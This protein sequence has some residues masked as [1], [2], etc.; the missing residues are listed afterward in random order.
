MDPDRQC[1][2]KS[3][4]SGNRCK[5]YAV[6]GATVCGTHGGS[7]P[8]VRDA[9][10]RR[11]EDAKAA[12]AVATYGLPV[13]VEPHEALLTEVRRTA[14]HVAW[15]G[16]IVED[17]EERTLTHGITRTVQKADGSRD[18]TAEAAVNVWVRLYQDERDRLVRVARAAIECGVAERQ[19]RIVEEQA[20]QLARVVSAILS[21]LGHDLEDEG[22]RKV[23]RLRMLQ[24]GK[25]A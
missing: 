11:T 2:A 9:A 24:G 13:D 23:V 15:L 5:K 7:A 4:R 3:T 17:L 1:T 25:A 20:T 21:D 6:R 8:Q 16:Q 10:R 14:G 12:A 18:V 19:V 22:V